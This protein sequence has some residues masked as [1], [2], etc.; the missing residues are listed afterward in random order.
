MQIIPA[1]DLLNGQCV[2]LTQGSFKKVKVYDND[3]VVTAQRYADAGIQRLHVVDLNAARGDKDGTVNL[4]TLEQI[5]LRTDMVID[6]GGGIR[7]TKDI[8]RAFRHGAQAITAGT[9]AVTKPGLVAQWLKDFGGA[10]V[11]MG[12]DC[13]NR[14]IATN[15][16]Q[17]T[18]DNTI[19]AFL[20]YF[21]R[22]G[23]TTTI[24]TEISRDGTLKGPDLQLY[25][26]IQDHTSL[27]V[28]ASGGVGQ[29]EDLLKLKD[30][31]C[32]GA[33]IGKAIYE[34]KITLQELSQLC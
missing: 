8:Q 4:Q 23:A 10:S 34:N 13:Q 25:Q 26:V 32:S 1:I 5:A 15:G 20:Q 29:Y 19:I 12:A 17:T 11:I 6:F 24:A 22:Q 9:V 27:A 31:G 14:C 21:E 18:S 33:I 30:L 16:W 28:I 7:S 3:P 2:R